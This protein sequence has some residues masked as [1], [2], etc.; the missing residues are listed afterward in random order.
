MVGDPILPET[1]WSE[2]QVLKLVG[3]GLNFAQLNIAWD[4]RPNNE[5]LNLEHMTDDLVNEFDRRVKLL[6]K[7]GLKGMFHFGMPK[8][9]VLEHE[10]NIT[11][12]L[13]PACISD[14]KIL[15]ENIDMITNLMQ[16]LPDVN[17]YMFYTYDQHAWLCS[18]FGECPKCAGVPLDMRLPQYINSFKKAMGEVNGKAMFW[19]QPWELSLGQICEVL[20]K[21]T[22]D[23]FGLMLNTAGS[24]SYF[25]NLDNL[26]LRCI[27]QIAAEKNIPIIVEIQAAGS[28]VGA[29]PVSDFPCP[30]FVYRQLKLADGL[31]TAVGIKEHFGFPLSRISVNIL[32]LK[33]FLKNPDLSEEQLLDN[34]AELYGKQVKAQLVKAYKEIEYAYDFI[35]FTFTYL[36]SNIAGYPTK[37]DFNVPKVEGV[38]ADTPAWESDRRAHF[39]ITKDMDYHPWALEDTALR[40]KQSGTRFTECAD[41]LEDAA[42]KV[43]KNDTDKEKADDLYRQAA[44]VRKMAAANL[45]QYYYFKESLLAYDIRVA[46]FQNDE[47]KY[48]MLLNEF[49]KI[50]QADIKNQNNDKTICDKYAEF[51]QDAK[52]FM[53]KNFKQDER[54]WS[55]GYVTKIDQRY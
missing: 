14:G 42:T 6:K 54:Y 28:G 10:A 44:A 48:I 49:D 22:T 43:G 41:I 2:E 18:E 21:I 38:F 7:H 26:W 17:D 25:N 52:L 32:F 46:I 37:H 8:V 9:K 4:N 30:T 35:P 33:E 11:P 5:P 53:Q 27:S 3:L 39:L 1:E 13:T 40:F 51:K 55:K 15:S 31:K 12:Y 29:V 24:E 20:T 36:Y 34:T 47:T 23:N 16:K 19:W 50:M 45:G